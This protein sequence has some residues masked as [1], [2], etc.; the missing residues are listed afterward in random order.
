MGLA[1]ERVSTKPVGN[2]DEALSLT[3]FS[4]AWLSIVARLK[5]PSYKFSSSALGRTVQLAHQWKMAIFIEERRRLGS[6]Q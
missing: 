1:A 4:S 5:F 2:L 6:L 3:G